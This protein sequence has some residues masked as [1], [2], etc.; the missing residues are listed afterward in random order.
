MKTGPK[1]WNDPNKKLPQF[2]N[3]P[4]SKWKWPKLRIYQNSK[5]TKIQNWPK[6]KTPK[7]L[8]DPNPKKNQIKKWLKFQID[9]NPKMTQI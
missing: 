6:L 7:F 4:S 1:I 3:G 9:T 5:K 8:I 2:K